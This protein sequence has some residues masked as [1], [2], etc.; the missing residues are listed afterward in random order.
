VLKSQ[1]VPPGREVEVEVTFGNPAE[2]T[3]YCNEFLHRIFGQ[4]GSFI[5][6]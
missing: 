6:R 2:Y 3:L 4:E 5:A 1:D